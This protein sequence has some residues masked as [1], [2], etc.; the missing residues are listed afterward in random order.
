LHFKELEPLL[1]LKDKETEFASLGFL[2]FAEGVQLL[3]SFNPGKQF[4]NWTS[5]TVIRL[6]S[7]WEHNLQVSSPSPVRKSTQHQ[8]TED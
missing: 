5:R 1:L 7:R 4:P 2:S 8:S 6:C 3:T